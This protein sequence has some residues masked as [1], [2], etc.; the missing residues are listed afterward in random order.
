MS[1]YVPGDKSMAVVK[2]IRP[3]TAVE[4]AFELGFYEGHY[5]VAPIKDSQS[6]R[7]E[8]GMLL[9]SA[10]TK[11]PNCV[12]P[13]DDIVDWV[14]DDALDL[15][16]GKHLMAKSPLDPQARAV[17]LINNGLFLRHL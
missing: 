1:D 4:R 2:G 16:S 7:P 11:W 17:L 15:L 6:F 14:R 5:K 8:M 12:V 10:Q 13:F 3:S 9:R